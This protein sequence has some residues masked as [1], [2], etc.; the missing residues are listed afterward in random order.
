VRLGRLTL[1]LF[2]VLQVADGLMTFGAVRIFGTVAEANPIL[3]TWIQ[4]A[5][6]AAALL[7]AKG[8]ACGGAA[9]L[10]AFGRQR[11]LAA[12]TGGVLGCAVIPWLALLATLP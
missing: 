5:G 8:I 12:L 1:T 9:V 4:V 10:Y 2:V 11:T 6:P 3:E 7:G